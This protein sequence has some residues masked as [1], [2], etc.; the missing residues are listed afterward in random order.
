MISS[1]AL[2]WMVHGRKPARQI[3]A[4]AQRHRGP[5]RSWKYKA[6]IRS[7]PCCCCGSTRDV[8]AAH[9]GDDGGMSQK[10]SDY[11]CVPCCTDC[12]TMAPDSHHR[13]R[14][15]FEQRVESAQGCT[16][17]DLVRRLNHDWFAYAALVK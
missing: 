9:T 6:W 10:S 7:L 8:E 15:A 4:S 14:A 11:S 16:V 5:A 12:H 17:Q 3:R 13:D 2:Y 1:R